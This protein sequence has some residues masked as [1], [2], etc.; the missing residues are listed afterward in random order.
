MS[1]KTREQQLDE[2]LDKQAR[3]A[4][5]RTDLAAAATALDAAQA[6]HNAAVDA[7]RLARR[8]LCLLIDPE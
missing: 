7:E 3:L 5:A 4:A 2:L 8:A 6:A 1:G